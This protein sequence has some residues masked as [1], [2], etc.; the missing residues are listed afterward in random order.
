MLKKWWRKWAPNPLDR[1]L[2]KAQRLGYKR[3]LIPWNRGLGDIALGLYAMVER[4]HTYIPDAQITFMTRL[5][6]VDG[7][8]LLEKCHVIGMPE[9][10]RG[11]PY[12]LPLDLSAYDMV[13]EN[14]DP[15][16]WVAWQRGH[17]TPRLKW[18][19]AWDALCNKFNVPSGCVG[20]HVQCETNYYQARNWPEDHF[21]TLFAAFPAQP[22]I[23][24]GLKKTPTFQ[25]SHLID[26]RGELS[27]YEMISMIK[28]KC[29]A[30]IAPD[31]GVL[32][33]TYYLATDFPLTVISLWADPNHGVLKQ[34]V[35][36][37]NKLLKHIPLISPNKKNAA[38]IPVSSVQEALGH[39]ITTY[40]RPS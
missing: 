23:L 40:P 31:S 7:F 13:I 12:V 21:R 39:V 28:N 4:I 22:F 34:N 16:Y 25:G 1:R 32:S 26:L 36:S 24:F 2:K 37:P 5:D 18:N 8:R 19:P 35:A 3:I 9:W 14:A 11:T 17:L 20:V 38:L 15:T 27:L 29:T 33:M 10:K 30:L 6:L